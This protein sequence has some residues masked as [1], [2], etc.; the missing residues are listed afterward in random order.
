MMEKIFL[1][2]V[3]ITFLQIGRLDLLISFEQDFF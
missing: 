3:I 1:C 2:L